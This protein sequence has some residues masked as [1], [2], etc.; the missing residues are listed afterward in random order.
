MTLSIPD[1]ILAIEPYKP[2]KPIEE[3]ERE[4][5]IGDSVKLASNENPL[6]PSPKALAAIGEHLATLHRYPDGGGFALTAKLAAKYGIAAS[7]I[8]LGNGSDDVI[9]MLSRALLRPGDE[10]LLPRPSFLMY[11]ISVQSVGA[12]P[13]FVPLNDALAIDLEAMRQ[14]VTPRT[15]LVFLCNPNNPTGTVISADALDA[16]LQGLPPEITVV[17]D[18]AYIEFVRALNCAAGLNF[19]DRGRPVVTLRTFSK[20]YGLAG[21]R[22]GYGIMP[23]ALAAI[24]HRV[25][26]PFNAGSLAQAGAAAALDDEAFLQQTI[27]LVHSGLDDLFAR[28][29]AIGVRY[30]PTQ[31]NFFLIDVRTDADAVF[32]RLLAEGV[33]VRSMRSYGYPHYIRVN[34]GLPAE[35]DR[36][37]TALGR[38]LK[39]T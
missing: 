4:H 30:F 36:F 31:A 15:R 6:G 37:V 9:V 17:L 24:L 10:A 22:I 39:A 7:A 13:V 33:I 20:A 18:E 3:L 14:R 5:G 34:A 12:R 8:V 23:P 28:L 2:G 29:D 11:A 25:R 27:R 21:L 1:Y 38:V 19:L 26:Q 16:F 32:D 35:N